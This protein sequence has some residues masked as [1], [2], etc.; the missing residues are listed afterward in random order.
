[1]DLS[2][3]RLV[4]SNPAL[5]EMLGYGE[6]ELRGMRPDDLAHPDDLETGTMPHER[7]LAGELDHYR[8]EKRYVRKDGRVLWGRL[9]ASLVREGGVSFLVL[10]IEDATERNDLVVAVSKHMCRVTI[11][12][13]G[14]R[15][16]PIPLV[17]APVAINL[18]WHHR[19]DTDKAHTWLRTQVREALQAISRLA[20]G[21]Q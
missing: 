19:H 17:L 18:A 15:T 20:N 14:L 7:L 3:G 11:A 6:D 5:R 16:L 10:V 8:T 1:M 2:S 21:I 13:L 9:T 12:A 4:R